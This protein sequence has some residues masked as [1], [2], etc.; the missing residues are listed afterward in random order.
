MSS[1]PQPYNVSP[2]V[3]TGLAAASRGTQAA[4]KL[5]RSFSADHGERLG[6]NLSPIRER[7]MKRVEIVWTVL[8][9]ILLIHGSQFKNLFLC[10]QVIMEFCFG[11]VKS[12]YVSLY[13]DVMTA[14]SKIQGDEPTN[15]STIKEEP[16]NKHAKKRQDSKKDSKDTSPSN[17]EESAAAKK[18]LKSV[19]ADKVT[20]AVFELFAG[21]MACHMVM[22]GGLARTAVVTHV[23]VKTCKLKLKPFIDFSDHADMQVWLDL[24]LSLVLY[25]GFGFTAVFAPSWAFAINLGLIG[26]DMVLSHGLRIAENMGKIPGGETAEQFADSMTGFLVYVVLVGCG[27]LWQFWAVMAESGVAWYF[28]MV[29]LPAYVGES[30]ISLL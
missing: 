1:K 6:R 11:R 29:Y 9:F 5:V 20:S 2:A 22:Q 17:D 10:T 25:A 18:M 3:T 16:E 26:S 21:Y 12:A 23:L 4:T 7:I 19:D 27:S 15:D 8:G 24:F 13:E 28:Q 30:L 14:H